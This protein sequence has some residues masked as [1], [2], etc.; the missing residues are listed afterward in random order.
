MEIRSTLPGPYKVCITCSVKSQFL[1][2]FNN[3]FPTKQLVTAH[4]S[5]D[6]SKQV[7][8]LDLFPYLANFYVVGRVLGPPDNTGTLTY[9]TS[10]FSPRTSTEALVPVGTW[11]L[12]HTDGTPFSSDT[13]KIILK[14]T[15]GEEEIRLEDFLSVVSSGLLRTLADATESAAEER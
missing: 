4:D 8:H 9:N 14:S 11:E 5:L 3:S 1:V 12:S 6:P 7:D 2:K 10:S 15:N 13:I